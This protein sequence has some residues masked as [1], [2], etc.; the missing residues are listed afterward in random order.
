[1]LAPA[2]LPYIF[3]QPPDLGRLCPTLREEV[4]AGL[5]FTTSAPPALVVLALP[6]LSL[7]YGPVAESPERSW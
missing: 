7:R 3:P 5:P 2:C 6:I 4:V 1:M